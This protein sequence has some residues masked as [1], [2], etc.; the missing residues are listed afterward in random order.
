M[1]FWIL[2]K[3]GKNAEIPLILKLYLVEKTVSLFSEV[4]VKAKSEEDAM[5]IALKSP[6]SLDWEEVDR[7]IDYDVMEAYDDE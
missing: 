6:E 1:F 3:S 2:Q 7:I 5:V 4:Y